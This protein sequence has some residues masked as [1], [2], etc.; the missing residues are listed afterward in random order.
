MTRWPC[1][2]A[3]LSL[4]PT[5][6]ADAI[7]PAEQL[8][9]L[10]AFTAYLGRRMARVRELSKIDGGFAWVTVGC[11]LTASGG[12]AD[13]DPADVEEI[14]AQLAPAKTKGDSK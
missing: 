13:I 3:R 2:H 12:F 5:V 14:V 1:G 8:R 10:K 11:A 4:T 6:A 7:D 9:V